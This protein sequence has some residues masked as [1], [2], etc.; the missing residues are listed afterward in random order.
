MVGASGFS[1]VKEHFSLALRLL[2]RCKHTFFTFIAPKE[3]IEEFM[4]TLAGRLA[5]HATR[6][7]LLAYTIL[8][9][10]NVMS[11]TRRVTE[12]ALARGAKI[13]VYMVSSHVYLSGPVLISH[14]ICKS[15]LNNRLPQDRRKSMTTQPKL[16]WVWP[17][18]ITSLLIKETD[19]IAADDAGVFLTDRMKDITHVVVP[20]NNAV[21]PG[22]DRLLKSFYAKNPNRL[23][24]TY[25]CGPAIDVKPRTST[26]AMHQVQAYLKAA[27][28]SGCHTV[29]FSMGYILA[30]ELP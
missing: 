30:F 10:E 27:K 2:E 1:H 22:Q 18:C 23:K 13:K 14:S 9:N 24:E 21:E 17:Q 19:A 7:D 12:L 15:E 3:R 20:S 16:V 28:V 11:A 8:A 26:D 6:L 4:Q 5:D 29:L 25:Y